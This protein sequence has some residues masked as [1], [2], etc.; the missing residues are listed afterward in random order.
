M[1]SPLEIENYFV[2]EVAFRVNTELKDIEDK[3]GIVDVDFNIRRDQDNPMNF[4]IQMSVDLNKEA[5]VFADSAYQI[6]LK[7]VGFFHFV[8][9]IDEDTISKMIAPIG[10]SILYGTARGIAAQ[11]TANS[12]YGKVVLPSVNFIEI[13]KK[14]LEVDGKKKKKTKKVKLREQVEE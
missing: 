12:W 4:N 9:G 11:V 13:I 14:R 2:E 1:H 7:L 6:N 10:L 3:P 5:K 8:D